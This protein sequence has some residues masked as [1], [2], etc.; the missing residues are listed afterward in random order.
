MDISKLERDKLAR[1]QKL[2]KALEDFDYE[3]YKKDIE[4][5]NEVTKSIMQNNGSCKKEKEKTTTFSTIRPNNV[6]GLFTNENGGRNSDPINKMINDKLKEN[7]KDINKPQYLKALES[8][9]MFDVYMVSGKFF[10]YVYMDWLETT[11]KGTFKRDL[12]KYNIDENLDINE[13]LKRSEKTNDEPVKTISLRCVNSSSEIKEK[14]IKFTEKRI[15]GTICDFI[16]Q[17]FVNKVK[18]LCEKNKLENNDL[19]LTMFSDSHKRSKI[20]SKINMISNK[21]SKKGR[22]GGSNFII[23]S[24]KNI[25]AIINS[26]NGSYDKEYLGTYKFNKKIENLSHDL[27]VNNSLGDTII[28][29]KK[30]KECEP[31][32]Y[33]VVNEKTLNNFQFTEDDFDSINLGF[34][35]L[36]VGEHPEY[37]Y[38]SFEMKS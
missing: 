25:D 17:E 15:D 24:K 22:F 27:I 23:G 3:K 33:V 2:E 18:N 19:D 32:V 37:N 28:V 36:E 31:G 12:S 5:L 34:E 13:I 4:M 6:T 1:D 30:P 10:K 16:N 38:I 7:L 26:L 20:T 14:F 29:G 9:N 35:V 11:K 21:I 8:L